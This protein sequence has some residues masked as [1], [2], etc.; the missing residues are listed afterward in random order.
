M[1]KLNALKDDFKASDDED[2]DEDED[3]D[4]GKDEDEDE[5]EDEEGD[6]DKGKKTDKGARGGHTTADPVS[7]STVDESLTQKELS[8]R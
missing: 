3:D 4:D 7:F 8:K 1:S 2:E 5:D 6:A